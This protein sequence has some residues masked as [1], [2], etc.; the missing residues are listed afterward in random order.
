M[1]P[2]Y[3][4]SITEVELVSLCIAG[5]TKAQRMLFDMFSGRLM[6]VC[7]RFGRSDHEA[8]DMLQEAFIKIYSNLTAFNNTAGLMTWARTITV[9]TCI[10]YLRLK[11]NKMMTEDIDA[12][13]IPLDMPNSHEV[14]NAEDLLT[15]I[16]LLPI[17]YKSVFNLYELEGFSHKEIADILHITE[18]TS[19]SQ[20]AK[21]KKMLRQYIPKFEKIAG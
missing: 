18:S 7:R 1:S 8:E 11:Y 6:T 9:N 3:K 4:N 10:K 19:R 12:Y 15:I 14:L 16:N 20:L 5:D 2:F 21:A 13:A 17:G